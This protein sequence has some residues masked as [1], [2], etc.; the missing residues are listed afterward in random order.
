M[1][2]V[3]NGVTDVTACIILGRKIAVRIN[4]EVQESGVDHVAKDKEARLCFFAPSA[5][6]LRGM[7]R[8]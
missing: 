5:R 6:G 4:P 3:C 7:R 1:R 2:I 8:W